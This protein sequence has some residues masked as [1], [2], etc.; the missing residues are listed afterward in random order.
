MCI[1]DRIKSAWYELKPKTIRKC[2]I[3][4]GFLSA[5]C[6]CSVD[7][8]EGNDSA[9]DLIKLCEVANVEVDMIECLH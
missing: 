5:D 2:F 9:S 8:P 7:T 3:H 1:R 6:G 4:C